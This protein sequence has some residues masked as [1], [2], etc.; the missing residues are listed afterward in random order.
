MLLS[1]SSFGTCLSLILMGT[2]SYLKH[3]DYDVNAVAWIPLLCLSSAVY[4]SAI[5]MIPLPYVVASEIL[6]QNVNDKN[7]SHLNGNFYH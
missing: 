2:F 5:G 6:P 3:L 7:E 1:V 4:I